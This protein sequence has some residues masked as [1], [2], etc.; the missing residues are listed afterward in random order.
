MAVA[1]TRKDRTAGEFR[2]VAA[3]CK[4]AKAALRMLS[5]LPPGSRVIHSEMLFL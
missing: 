3:Q 2:V 4:D 1:I 5:D